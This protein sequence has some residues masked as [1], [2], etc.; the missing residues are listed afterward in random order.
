MEFSSSSSGIEK[1][2]FRKPIPTEVFQAVRVMGQGATTR[3]TADSARPE[4]ASRSNTRPSPFLGGASTSLPTQSPVS[5]PS[6]PL[7]KEASSRTTHW[8][9]RYDA[10]QRAVML[11]ASGLVLL[12]VILAC[13][14]YFSRKTVVEE[15]DGTSEQEPPTVT[16]Q[17]SPQV[18]LQSLPFSADTTNFLSFDT[19]TAT[20]ESLRALF[21]E[22]GEKIVTANMTTPVEFLLTDK[23]NN[24]VAFSRFVYL[25]ALGLPEDLVSALGETFSVFLYNDQGKIALGIVFVPEN[26]GTVQEIVKER[27][28]SLPFLFRSFLF[29]STSVSKSVT[30]RSGTYKE[31]VVRYVNVDEAQGFSFDYVLRDKEWVIGGSK[32]TLRAILDKKIK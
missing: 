15:G 11:G 23:N 1:K 22:A 12:L 16:M 3:E 13:Y 27:E 9:S 6:L 2:P 26:M 4:A 10:K 17:S 25:M 19:E 28:S 14:W 32:N 21:A 31:E 24:P 30:F 18:V 8:L 5:A 20:P 29:G 7:K